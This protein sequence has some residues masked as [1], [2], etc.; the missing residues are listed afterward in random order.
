MSSRFRRTQ[1]Q[2]E[3][4]DEKD[5]MGAFFLNASAST[6]SDSDR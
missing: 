1:E 3:G 4:K 6:G 2:L 5:G